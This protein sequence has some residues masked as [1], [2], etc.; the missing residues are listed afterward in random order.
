M[1]K[2]YNIH[3]KYDAGRKRS[4]KVKSGGRLEALLFL[5]HENSKL[6][7]NDEHKNNGKLLR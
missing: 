1:P 5:I 3:V 4:I 7:S 6:K 2:S